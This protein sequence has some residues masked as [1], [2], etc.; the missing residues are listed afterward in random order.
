MVPLVMNRLHCPPGYSLIPDVLG[1]ECSSVQVGPGIQQ[2]GWDVTAGESGICELLGATPEMSRS[3]RSPKNCYTTRLGDGQGAKDTGSRWTNRENPNLPSP[4]SCPDSPLQAELLQGP[5]P[6]P[7]L[8]LDLYLYF[9]AA[10]CSSTISFITFCSWATR[11][12]K[13]GD[14]AYLGVRSGVRS[15]VLGLCTYGHSSSL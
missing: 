7:K 2:P 12:G 3:V 9:G 13:D 6:S 15:L 5:E 4:N 1:L 11:E 14:T 10:S 8:L